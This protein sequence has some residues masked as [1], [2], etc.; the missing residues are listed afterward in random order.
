MAITLDGPQ[1]LAV[2]HGVATAIAVGV[3]LIGIDLKDAMPLA[4]F[5]VILSGLACAYLLLLALPFTFGRALAST[6]RLHDAVAPV[7]YAV[8]SAVIA[9]TM[10]GSFDVL[11]RV[12]TSLHLF[13]DAHGWFAVGVVVL[14]F[15]A[16]KALRHLPIRV[17]DYFALAPT[18]SLLLAM[19]LSSYLRQGS[20]NDLALLTAEAYHGLSE[21]LVVLAAVTAAGWLASRMRRMATS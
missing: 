20:S 18:G 15:I 2:K 8:W 9:F 11:R 4:G 1:K 10:A 12:V 5:V 3:F 14:A 19:T 21:F 7:A 16:Y 6:Q 17:E 13:L